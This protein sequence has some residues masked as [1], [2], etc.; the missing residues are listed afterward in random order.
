[1]IVQKHRADLVQGGLH[2]LNLANH[3]DAV[4]IFLRHALNALDV[5]S[6]IGQ[7]SRDLF[8]CRIVHLCYPDPPGGGMREL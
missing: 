5:A 8:A 2:G 6:R 4:S 1:M 3:V 7:P